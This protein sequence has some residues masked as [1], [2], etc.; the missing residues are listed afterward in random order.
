M[1]AVAL[2]Y[3]AREAFGLPLP[4]PA[5]RR[6]VPDWWRSFFSWPVAATLYGAGLGIG[7]LTFLSNGG[8]VVVAVA[9][10]ASGRPDRRAPWWWARSGSRAG[11]PPLAAWPVRTREAGA[12]LVDRL[13]ARD[14]AWWRRVNAA[15][16]LLVGAAVL[17]R[18]AGASAGALRSTIA[19]RG[20]VGAGDRVRVVG[21]PR[22]WS[23]PRRWRR[24]LAAHALPPGLDAR[25]RGR[26]ARGGGRRA[27]GGDRRRSGPRP[28]RSP[29]CS[30]VGFSAAIVRARVRDGRDA[31]ACGCF[32]GSRA[33]DYRLLL[34]RNAALAARRRRGLAASPATSAGGPARRGRASSCPSRWPPR[35]SPW[36]S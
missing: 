9:A 27:R 14:P 17:L 24:T 13:A 33:R 18:L 8:L 5:A 30:L 7:F 23:R 31:V 35:P 32:G 11:S 10:V 12:A 25:G 34:A 16:L 21:A 2:A 28:A 6:Q 26:R 3:A 36:Q 29:W 19:G 22:S 15:A 4:V 1:A 20:R